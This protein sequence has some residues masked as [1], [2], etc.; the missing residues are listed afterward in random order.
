MQF[1]DPKVLNLK[2]VAFLVPYPL[3]ESPSQRFRFEQYFSVLRN[4]EIHYTVYPFLNEKGWSVLYARGKFMQK[5]WHLVRG[6]VLRILHVFYTGRA[7]F[8]FIHREAAPLG[9]PIFEWVIAKL[10]RKK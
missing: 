9:P 6:F 2:R 5:L 3:D 4:H 8:V 7:D 1:Y 10:F